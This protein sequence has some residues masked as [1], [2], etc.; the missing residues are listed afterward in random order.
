MPEYQLD[1]YK[2]P[3]THPSRVSPYEQTNHIFTQYYFSHPNPWNTFG[4][5]WNQHGHTQYIRRRVHGRADV[6]AAA[7]LGMPPPRPGDISTQ[8][9]SS[10]DTNRAT[11]DR[12][13]GA[14]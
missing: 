10:V 7:L 6:D 2:L 14:A 1:Q 12:P 9:H 4:L 8:V 11:N 5:L 3:I 13:W